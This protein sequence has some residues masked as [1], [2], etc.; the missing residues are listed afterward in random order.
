VRQDFPTTYE[1]FIGSV[2]QPC[3]MAFYISAVREQNAIKILACLSEN[4]T[5]RILLM[6]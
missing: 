4:F 2:F 6:R 5:V 1:D 3:E